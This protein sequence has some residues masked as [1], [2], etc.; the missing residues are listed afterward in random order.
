MIFHYNNRIRTPGKNKK[1]KKNG[2]KYST[3]NNM[4]S[5]SGGDVEWNAGING[6]WDTGN[7]D[8]GG[9]GCDSGGGGDYGGGGGCDSGGGGGDS[10]G[11]G[12]DSG[13]GGCDSGGG[14]SY[15]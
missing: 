12:C 13:G 2:A 10:G 11:G 4:N 15:D 8:S 1:A 3:S 5:S 7:W 9:G 6:I 14:S